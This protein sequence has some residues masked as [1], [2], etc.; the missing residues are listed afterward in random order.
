[1]NSSPAVANGI[2][3]IGSG[4]GN[5]YMLN[6]T[7]GAK[8][9]SAA[10]G[11]VYGSSPAVANGI[12]YISSTRG[13]FV[14]NATTGA[15]VWSANIGNY[16]VDSSP[17]VANGIVYV[18]SLGFAGYPRTRRRGSSSDRPHPRLRIFLAGGG[19]RD[20][21]CWCQRRQGL[22]AG[23]R[24]RGERLVL[25]DGRLRGLF[26]GGGQRDRLCRS[27]DDKVYALNATTGAP[28]WSYATKNLVQSS[29][30]VA[31]GVLYVGSNDG[32][33]YAFKP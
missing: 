1:M 33:V 26:A 8:V 32:K 16:V 2:V 4:D 20:R 23:T 9:W 21:L 5:I 17:A 12:V 11:I 6:A 15:K 24:R 3:Y 31:N 14:R 22:R 13:L 7:T 30:A 18:G 19:Q 27:Q 10:T 28:V 29:P 25:H